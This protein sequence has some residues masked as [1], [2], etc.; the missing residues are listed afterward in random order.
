MIY[1]GFDIASD[2][3][4]FFMIQAETGITFS[5]SSITIKNSDDGY[6]KLHE[7]IQDFCGATG[8]S[9][10][11]IG[12][13]STGIYH[14]NIISFLLSQNYQ[15]MMINP[16]LTNMARKASKVHS[17]KNDNLDSQT[18]CKYM[19]DNSDKFSPYRGVL[20]SNPW[21]FPHLNNAKSPHSQIYQDRKP[22]PS[23]FSDDG[24]YAN[25]SED[26]LYLYQRAIHVEEL[27]VRT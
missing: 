15:V 7:S 1:V 22:H 16:I 9:Q 19:I 27:T 21:E 24:L 10:I 14:A 4:D 26:R 3:H 23:I 13:E 20:P 25:H 8:D 11:R 17:P 18:I 6:K 5:K 12:L 2:K